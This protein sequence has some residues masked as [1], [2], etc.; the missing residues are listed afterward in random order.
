[1][2]ILVANVIGFSRSGQRG[3]ADVH[4]QARICVCGCCCS[5]LGLFASTGRLARQDTLLAT[6]VQPARSTALVRTLG[7]EQ[8]RNRDGDGFV[9]PVL[10]G[11]SDVTC[12]SLTSRQ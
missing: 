5:E 7:A 3:L 4:L 2:T 6:Y 10:R 8:L 9:L 11:K 1:M 12:I